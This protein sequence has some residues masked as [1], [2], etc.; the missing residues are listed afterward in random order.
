[1]RHW[2]PSPALLLVLVLLLAAAPLQA[3]QQAAPVDT[4]TGRVLDPTGR[5]VASALVRATDEA[6]RTFQTQTDR[7]GRYRLI[8][9][10]SSRYLMTA[11]AA[12]HAATNALVERGSGG[13]IE[14]DLSLGY[15]QLDPLK[16]Q[17]RRQKVQPAG[18]RNTP[19]QSGSE[20]TT[21]LMEQY[22]ATPGDLAGI[23]A[24]TP[25]IAR[26]DGSDTGAGGLSLAGQAPS[27]NGTTVDGASFGGASLP[28]E[29]VRRTGVV[30]SSYDVSRGQFAGAQ[31][32]ATT[33]SGTNLWGGALS[34][35]LHDPT[36]RYGDL[37]GTGM[38][39]R[40]RLLQLD[41]G[42][43][44]PLVRNR[45]FIYGAGQLSR[46]AYPVSFLETSDALTLR[47]LGLSSDSASRFLDVGR[48]LGIGTSAP[49]PRE[50]STTNGLALLRLD[51]TLSDA[52]S[53]ALRLDG[54]VMESTGLGAS[55]LALAGNAGRSESE[56]GGALLQLTSS[57]ST[58]ANE[59]R[60]Y[61]AGGR[62]HT[63]SDLLLPAGS[64]RIGSALE[65]YGTG[66]ATLRF[67]GHSALAMRTRQEL[68]ELNDQ[69]S[70][71]FRDGLH[72]VTLGVQ[73]QE[74]KTVL[75]GRSNTLGT[76]SFQSLADLEAGSPSSFTRTLSAVRPAATQRYAAAYLGDVWRVREG[77]GLVYGLRA[78][79][80]AYPDRPLA[81][82]TTATSAEGRAGAPPSSWNLSPRLGFR[83][84][85]S[86]RS[87]IDGG[88]GM[89]V[90]RLPLA[91]MA[92]ALYENG[93]ASAVLNCVGPAAPTPEWAAYAADPG[94]IPSTCASGAPLFSD[95]RDRL[96][97]F[98]PDFRVPRTWRASLGGGAQVRN[99]WTLRGDALLV[100]G[101][102]QP[103]AKEQNLAGTSFALNEEAGRPVFAPPSAIDPL[104]GGIAP[105]ATRLDPTLASVR[106]LGS[107]GR[108][109]AAQFTVGTSG[110][111]R[112][113]ASLGL[114]YTYT[115]AWDAV[116][117][118][119]TLTGSTASTPADPNRREWGTGDF[120][121]RHR[122]QGQFS[123]RLTRRAN[124][125]VLANLTSGRPFTPLV[126][127][128]INGDGYAND[129]AFIFNPRAA[130]DTALARGMEHL[131]ENGPTHARSCL[132][133][134][135]GQVAARNSCRTPWT[136]SL[137]AQLFI[138][139][140][141]A[142]RRL[143]VS[144]VASNVTAGMDYLLHGPD[145]LRGWG[146]FPIINPVLLQVRGFDPDRKAYRYEVNPRFGELLSTRGGLR[147]PFTLTLQARVTLGAD[148]VYQQFAAA[149][150]SALQSDRSPERL[151]P[152]ISARMVNVPLQ[153]L[154]QNGPRQLE[155]TP[156]Q[157]KRLTQAADTLAPQLA[158]A[159]DSLVALRSSSLTQTPGRQA[160][161]EELATRGRKLVEA[162]VALAREV[163]SAEQWAKLPAAVTQP[164]LDEPIIPAIQL[165][166]S[167][168]DL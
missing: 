128:D 23:A 22:P 157:Y 141:A 166:F 10:G 137:D 116:G 103:S 21:Q 45:L 110:L 46:R 9:S 43:G 130:Q 64:V 55:P 95:T 131:L 135:L 114:Y 16:V 11:T 68:L 126:G 77:L 88:I 66:W 80:Y 151:R 118:V 150:N 37:P 5:P 155:L 48:T 58:F 161:M 50:A 51:Y 61:R 35:R 44:G 93:A 2:L 42:V 108:S 113:M 102:A 140:L 47:R 143:Q 28:A 111:T 147:T 86:K 19:G 6:G 34:T 39:Q 123:R 32:A 146:Q 117:G 124:L 120:E 153:V 90:G 4:L 98:T 100:R 69:L 164:P 107:D 84:S 162:G 63:S 15:V 25:G 133:A 154:S 76:Y 148:P 71:E 81:N 70:L 125:S 14:Q 142:R 52:H 53:L 139:P 94:R 30:T 54:R 18:Q 41:G 158:A 75:G 105:G 127:G 159:V 163:L 3:Q 89:F 136:P 152:L 160:Q 24:L 165:R 78:E 67:G 72:R 1:V 122:L 65:E 13:R 38:A 87:S 115:R 36:L 168:G 83:L 129:R 31:V 85:P 8:M 138:Q 109:W 96:T 60:V 144:V 40:A 145:R 106:E 121:Q 26:L 167:T 112:G 49:A 119:P 56:N 74:E 17:A 149:I 104:S 82:T 156:A 73:L 99:T 92:G 62:Q 59:L 27:Q 79:R 97:L 91:G 134:Q 57:F 29:A 12:S 132:R 33:R 7:Q 101:V 20:R